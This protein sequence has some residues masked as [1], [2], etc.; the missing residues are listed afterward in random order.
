M[1]TLEILIGI[2]ICLMSFLAFLYLTREVFHQDLVL[3]DFQFS[4]FAYI[5]RT[6]ELTIIMKFFSALGNSISLLISTLIVIILLL[7]KHRN[8]VA[9]FCIA[10]IMGTVINTALKTFIA[11]ERPSQ[12]P[13]VIENT[14]SFPS[15]H[16]MNAT[17][18]FGLISYFSFHFFRKKSLSVMISLL[19]ILLI[20]LIGFSRIYLGVHYFSDVMAGYFAGFW[21]F[22]T[23]L[24]VDHTLKFYKL[25][26]EESYLK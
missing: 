5:L 24:L 25:F 1:I 22:V 10:L 17:I 7:K 19:S 16:A 11:R 9:I 12:S 8:E 15:N 3:V 13:L 21:W 6:P 2:V 23:V 18:F 26:K 14:Y 4:Q 20:I